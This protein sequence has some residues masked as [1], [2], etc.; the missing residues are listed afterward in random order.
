[1]AFV[2][3]FVVIIVALLI[4]IL[5]KLYQSKEGGKTDATVF[6]SIMKSLGTL[7]ATITEKE[8]AEEARLRAN[9]ERQ[10][11]V[12]K[13][14]EDFMRT[15][16][17]TRKRGVVGESLLKETLSI[18]IKTGL[19]KLG[20]KV[21]GKEVEFAWDVGNGKYL[22]IDS[23]LP[24]VTELFEKFDKTEDVDEQKKIKKDIFLTRFQ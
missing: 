16:S 5:W 19:I 9:Q 13:N 1:M 21:D 12:E 15:I 17:G 23:K 11:K 14:I 18:A 2:E 24:D 3:F 20:L 10:Q 6:G 4:F 7:E 8:K 22:P